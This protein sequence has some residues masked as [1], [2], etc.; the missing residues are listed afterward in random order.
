VIPSQPA[1]RAQRPAS[2]EEPPM[3]ALLIVLA[4][5]ILE[6]V[7]HRSGIITR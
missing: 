6:A 7:D 1:G 5:C 2:S 3:T 4:L